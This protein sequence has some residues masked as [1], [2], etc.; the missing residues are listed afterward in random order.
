[1]KKGFIGILIVLAYMAAYLY[2]SM[3]V[4]SFVSLIGSLDLFFKPEYLQNIESLIEAITNRALSGYSVIWTL[5]ITNIG[6]IIFVLLLNRKSLK[7]TGWFTS[8]K[9]IDLVFTVIFAVGCAILVSFLLGY[10]FPEFINTMPVEQQRVFASLSEVNPLLV[11]FTVGVISPLAEE[12]LFR[13]AIYNTLRVRINPAVAI[14]LSAILFGAFHMNLFQGSYATILGL[15]MGIIIYK[16]GSLVLPIIF[17]I[18]Y[19]ILVSIPDM[20]PAEVM[21]FLFVRTFILPIIGLLLFNA[22]LVYFLQKGKEPED[23][24]SMKVLS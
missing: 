24:P 18:V 9:K 17:H 2:L 23:L 4:S 22:A 6:F 15:A 3:N 20:I 8:F 13:G 1:M 21:S 14:L 19:N 11:I 7:K 5:L 10:I 16:S 12:V